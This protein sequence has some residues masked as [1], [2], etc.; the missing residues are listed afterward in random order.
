MKRKS[1]SSVFFP[2]EKRRGVLGLLGRARGGV[3]FAAVAG[4]A[5]VVAVRAREE[6]AASIR[7]T[8]ATLTTLSRAVTSYRAD[9]GGECPP[10]FGDLVVGGYVRDVPADAWG[11]PFRLICP[12]R[13]D[14]TGFDLMSDGPDGLPEGLDR[15]E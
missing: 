4:V 10:A 9:H 5:L 7:A 15:V 2:W 11:N 14:K 13:K 3:L 1:E 6:R 12:G 8:R